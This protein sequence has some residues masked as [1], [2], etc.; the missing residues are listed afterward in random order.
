MAFVD[1]CRSQDSSTVQSLFPQTA[2][3]S[4][5]MRS[6]VGWFCSKMPDMLFLYLQSRKVTLMYTVRSCIFCKVKPNSNFNS[7]CLEFLTAV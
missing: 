3:S 4:A 1:T 7:I 5:F 2:E 6:F